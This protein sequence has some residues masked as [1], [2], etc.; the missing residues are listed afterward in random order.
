MTG[1]VFIG[2]EV[3]LSTLAASWERAVAGAP[4]LVAVWG[5]RRVGKTYLLNHFA[6]GK[7]HV[8]F[9][10]TRQDSEARQLER[11]TRRSASNSADGLGCSMSPG[12]PAGQAP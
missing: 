3:E 1:Q 4:Q 6:A 7:P 5:R 12:R 2:R 11:L 8:Y 10:A 9:T